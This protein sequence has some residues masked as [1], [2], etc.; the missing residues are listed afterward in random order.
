MKHYKLV[1]LAVCIL[2]LLMFGGIC[3]PGP[4]GG[5]GPDLVVTTFVTIGPPTLNFD[6]KAEVPIRVIVKNQG[7]VEAGIFRVGIEKVNTD[8]YEDVVQ[9]SVPGE[10]NSF[11]PITKAPLALGAT[12]TFEGK[13]IFAHGEHN[14]TL[15]LKAVA[16]SCEGLSNP[17]I[18][19]MVKEA[20]EDNNESTQISVSIP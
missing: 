12:V 4:G 7:T 15:S 9:F 8:P 1:L 18:G 14:I 17:T 16:D 10:Y 3:E 20:N 11:F 13:A 2:G 19:C 5:Y 6:E